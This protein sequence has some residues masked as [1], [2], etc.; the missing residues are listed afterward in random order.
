[1]IILGS[2]NWPTKS[3]Q[4]LSVCNIVLLFHNMN[5]LPN[6]IVSAS[7]ATF[8][9]LLRPPT[10]CLTISSTR[11]STDFS[12]SLP[13]TSSS[14]S[15]VLCWRWW[16]TGDIGCGTGVCCPPPLKSGAAKAAGQL[17][18]DLVLVECWKTLSMLRSTPRTGGGIGDHSCSGE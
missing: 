17:F 12:L 10:L 8:P 14:T 18:F 15:V 2:L 11:S 4:T 7:F 5:T 6:Q 16:W 3:C 13:E 1:M 9:Q